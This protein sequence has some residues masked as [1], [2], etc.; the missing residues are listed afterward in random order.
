MAI[1]EII[2]WLNS[3]QKYETGLKLYIQH[4]TNS[5]LKKVL[6]TGPNPFNTE[7]LEDELQLIHDSQNTTAR[8]SGVYR[9]RDYEGLDDAIKEMI[10]TVKSLYKMNGAKL[11]QLKYQKTDQKRAIMAH[12]ILDNDQQ[13]RE[14]LHQIDYFEEHGTIP[15]VPDQDLEMSEAEMTHLI[16]LIRSRISKN[17]NNP[18]KSRIVAQ[19]KQEII[20]LQFNLYALF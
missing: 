2:S 15:K 7:K 17:K 5:F 14:L 4:G 9:G 12:Q 1:P 20:L 8:S 19:W 11:A 10:A 13:A 3:D 16:R 18:E 6:A